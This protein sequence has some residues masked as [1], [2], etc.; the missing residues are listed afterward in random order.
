MRFIRYALPLLLALAGTG[1]ATYK[2]QDI[3]AGQSAGRTATADGPAHR[4][5]PGT[6]RAVA[7]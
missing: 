1:C 2:P 7:P 3:R 5:L 6:E 4:P